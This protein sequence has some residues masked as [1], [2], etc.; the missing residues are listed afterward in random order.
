MIH[1]IVITCLYSTRRFYSVPKIPVD[2]YLSPVS[3]KI[4]TMSF[5]LFSFFRLTRS[6]GR[7]CRAA[8]VAA[9][10]EIPQK[11]PSSIASLFSVL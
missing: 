11:S 5:P 2:R 1:I 9:P 10:E 4:T 7:A 3:G 8:Q 6:A